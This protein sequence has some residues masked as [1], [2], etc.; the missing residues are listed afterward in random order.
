MSHTMKVWERIFEARLRYKV[1]ISKR[2]KVSISII[3]A[4]W[5][6]VSKGNHRCDVCFKNVDR[7]VQGRLKRATLRIRGPRESLQQ[8]SAGRAVLLYKKIRNSGKVCA[9]CTGYVR[10]KRNSVEVCSR[11]YRK[12]QGQSCTAPRIALSLFLFAVKRTG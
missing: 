5:I 7:K 3:R 9:T 11:N 8:A 2:Y 1:N 4:I 10:G 12:F 6:Y